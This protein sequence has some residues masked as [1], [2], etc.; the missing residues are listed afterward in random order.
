[1]PRPAVQLFNLGIDNRTRIASGPFQQL[2]HEFRPF[3][4]TDLS[5]RWESYRVFFAPINWRFR[6]GDRFEFNANPV[7]ERLVAPFEVADGVVIAPGRYD[8]L[9]YRLEVGTAQKRR[10]YTQVTWW[11]GGFYDGTIDQVIWTGAWNPTALFTVEFTGERNMGRLP[12]GDFTQTLV[13][14][15]IRLNVSP[16]L[17]VS[18]YV[19]YDTVSDSVGVNSRLRW[20]FRPEAELF[21]VYNHNV[22]SVVDRWQLESNQLVMKVQYAFR[23]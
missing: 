6:S 12:A 11:F 16:N 15:R 9:Q 1:V 7:G 23:R 18:S 13:G 10:L 22:R 3:V 20:T 8:W 21:V 5:G 19:Q 4:A 14:N 2:V 17:S